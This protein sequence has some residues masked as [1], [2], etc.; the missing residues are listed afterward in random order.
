MLSQ[1]W[2]TPKWIVDKI[3][4][5]WGNI[6]LDPCSNEGS[7]VR[8]AYEVRLPQDGL[9]FDWYAPNVQTIFCNPP[10][11][12]DKERGTSIGD[13]IQKCADTDRAGDK[14]AST[15]GLGPGYKDIFL[16]IPASTELKAWHEHIWNDCDAICFFNRRIKFLLNG[17]EKAGSTKGS[18][19]VYYGQYEDLFKE[20]FSDCGK[21]LTVF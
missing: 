20:W 4:S 18:A 8:A 5:G 9:A 17:E 14:E 2:N 13:W 19:L 6:D 15:A 7:L 11:G 1:H 21:V 3:R 16:L 12:I 10:Y